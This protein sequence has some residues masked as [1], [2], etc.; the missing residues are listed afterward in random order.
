MQRERRAGAAP[1]P[2]PAPDEGLRGRLRAAAA[3]AALALAGLAAWL[4]LPD[5]TF[6][7]DGVMFAQ[8]VE[9]A[10]EDW[11]KDFFN[12]RHLLFNETFQ[13]LRDALLAVGVR[14]GAYR[15]FQVVN[16]LVGAVGLLLFGDL[17]RRLTRDAALGWCAALLLGATWCYGTRA[18]EGQVY[19]LMSVG[20]LATLWACARLVE[21]P[22]AGRAVA[23]AAAFALA[24]LYH[25]ADVFVAP[26]VVAAFWAAFPGR[27][28]HAAAAATGAAALLAV[29]YLLFFGHGGARAFFSSAADFHAA[30]GAGFWSGLFGKFWSGA[31]P[32][33]RLLTV[34]KETGLALAPMPDAAG[35]LVGAASWAAAAWA[36]RSAWPRLDEVRRRNAAAV[37]LAWAGFTVV[38]L[39]WPGGLFFYVLPHAC[40]LALLALGASPRWSALRGVERRR[41][42][43]LL[44][45]AGLALAAW[46][47]RAGLLPQ[48]RP[49]ANAGRR[50]ATWV[51][52]HTMPTSW[53]VITGLGFPNSK[54]YLANFARRSREVVEYHFNHLPKD[55]ALREVAEFAARETAAGVPLYFL[56]D[57][58]ESASVAAE[59]ER[60][61]GARM[62]EI[63]AAFG[64]GTVMR[65]ASSEDERVYLFV[66]RDR[67][68]ELFAGLGFSQLTEPA[69]AKLLENAAALKTLS[70]QMTPG[71]RR[72]AGELLRAKTW[73]FDLLAAGLGGYMSPEGR[74]GL[75]AR[76]AGVLER[77][78]TPDFWLRAGNLYSLLGLGPDALAAWR[79]AETLSGDPRLKEKI[80]LLEAARR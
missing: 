39:F 79:R 65:T 44:C 7:F 59:I 38:N 36:L 63:Q 20:A 32:A 77:E 52:K 48:S 61:W 72:R 71:E 13:L 14:V 8:S 56:S 25:A 34:W 16:A 60:L 5:Q 29:P 51:G 70:E 26:A 3:P 68:A 1:A 42:L 17:V 57:M 80:A 54:V 33:A 73:G 75:P 24:A 55:A 10:A 21:R 40:A 27:R 41:A 69:D 46:N 66:P 15:L 4:S 37:A 58:T 18:T 22:G 12:P 49:E 11:R 6:V 53:I 30:S 67:R 76:R 74:A 45:G 50:I 78:K 9:R 19:M 23:A 31:S 62:T 43:G 47:V 64:P 28:A 35:T 2:A